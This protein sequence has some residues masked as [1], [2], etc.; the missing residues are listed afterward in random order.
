MNDNIIQER[1]K[2]N[3]DNYSEIMFSLLRYYSILS[4]CSK[5]VVIDIACGTGYGS[6]ILANVAKKVIGYDKDKDTIENNKKIYNLN[7]LF[8]DICSAEKIKCDSKSVDVVVSCETIE[9]LNP[10]ISNLFLD[11]VLRVLKSKG[12]F[13]ITTPNKRKTEAFSNKNPFHINEFYMEDFE[14]ELHAKFK[15]VQMYFL[16]LN[17]ITY[18]KRINGNSQNLNIINIKN[19]QK[20]NEENNV[21]IYMAAL[22]SNRSLKNID[23]SSILYDQS[24]TLNEKLWNELNNYKERIDLIEKMEV[25]NEKRKRNKL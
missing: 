19:W 25:S 22:C 17:L 21:T 13:F 15:N 5:K 20:S 4:L 8:F 2:I 9:H 18:M 11:E 16:D 24:K 7:N 23:L 6:Y 12:I 1:L 14:K 10:K 3:S